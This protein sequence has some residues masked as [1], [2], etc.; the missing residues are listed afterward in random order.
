PLPAAG[1]PSG[2]AAARWRVGPESGRDVEARAPVLDRP[3]REPALDQLA[4]RW[5]QRQFERLAQ[6]AGSRRIAVQQRHEAQQRPGAVRSFQQQDLVASGD[7][8]GF[9]HP[10]VPARSPGVL[11]PSGH[12]GYAEALVELP[13]GLSCLRD[14][15]HRAADAQAITQAKPRLGD[16]RRTQVLAEGAGRG[17]CGQ[18]AELAGPVLVV[19]EGIGVNRLVGT[20]MEA[21]VALLVAV[22][23]G[24]TDAHPA[25]ARCL[26]DR[27]LAPARELD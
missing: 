20:A 4:P 15:E 5:H 17:K 2:G 19:L 21:G 22:E 25:C 3:G 7:L 6:G 16:A 14:C 18:G 9:E 10:E 24:G 8:A 23:P 26:G 11:Y 1:W 13:A 12:V 27:A